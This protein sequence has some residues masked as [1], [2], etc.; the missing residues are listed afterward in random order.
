M[1]TL[2]K[3]N[4][5][6]AVNHSSKPADSS[7]KLDL[8]RLVRQPRHSPATY[9]AVA[10]R[11]L[12]GALIAEPK[13]D[14]SS[15]WMDVD[16]AIV[17]VQVAA[18]CL[19]RVQAGD[20]VHAVLASDEVWVLSVLKRSTSGR[21]AVHE[22]DFGESELHISAKKIRM[23]ADQHL[24]INAPLLTQ[25]AKNRQSQIEGTDSAHVGNCIVHADSHM[26]LHARSAM[27]TAAS[28]LKVDA[29]QI[30]MG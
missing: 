4:N 5:I 6:C 27:V 18:S 30:H 19:L 22:L 24:H 7:P 20:W 15:L 17:P 25:T 13:A 28:L 2:E 10:A 23:S 12:V 26:S 29:A 1:N 16:G 11:T 8:E 9:G 14:D 3:I 21:D